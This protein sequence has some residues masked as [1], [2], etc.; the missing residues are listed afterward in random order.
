MSA[1]STHPGPALHFGD[2]NWIAGSA[3]PRD[4]EPSHRL[5]EPEHLLNTIDPITGH[6]IPV[7]NNPLY[8]V[9]G[10][11]TI[12]FESGQSMLDF[13]N[14]PL[15]HPYEHDLGKTPDDADRGG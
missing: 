9:D 4:R 13:L 3:L 5:H 12:Y 1:Q 8:L 7:I 11:L 10:K 6:D 2:L 14:M 15:N